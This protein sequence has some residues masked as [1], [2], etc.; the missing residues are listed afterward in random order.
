MATI[1]APATPRGPVMSAVRD[2]LP[3]VVAVAPFGMVVGVAQAAVGV[4]LLPGLAAA[5]LVYGGSAHLATVGALAAGTGVVGAVLTG[6]LVNARLLLYSADL[7]T[8]FADQPR[9]FRVVGSVTIIDQTH[10]LLPNGLRHGTD[11]LRRYW[12]TIGT[13]LALGWLTA[14]TIGARLG[15]VVPSGVQVEVAPKVVFLAM[16]LPRLTSPRMRRAVAVAAVAAVLGRSLPAGLGTILALLAAM[17]VAGRGDMP[18]AVAAGD[19][20][21]AA[22]DASVADRREVVPQG[23]TRPTVRAGVV[24]CPS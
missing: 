2:M 19:A 18:A 22:G 9:W 24:P 20:A 5:L 12:L 11:G 13:T 8:T 10:A 21:V 1:T 23:P 7:A 6:S 17:A 4:A 14:I 16:L 3:I 15:D